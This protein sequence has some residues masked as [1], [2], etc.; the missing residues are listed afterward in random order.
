ME[1]ETEVKT[2]EVHYECPNCN[3]V[4]M[5]FTGRTQLT[6]PPKY[7]HECPKCECQKSLSEKY[8]Y[9]KYVPVS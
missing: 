1:K 5:E 8:P 4:N 2:V 3:E 7:I 9:F 6:S